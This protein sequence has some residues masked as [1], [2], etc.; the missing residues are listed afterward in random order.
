MRTLTNLWHYA[1]LKG[2]NGCAF[3]ETESELRLGA[4]TGSLSQA[5]IFRSNGEK[6]ADILFFSFYWV[7]LEN[8]S[9]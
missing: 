9:L 5:F 7:W 1:L 8:W 2:A 6:G 4:L 3:S